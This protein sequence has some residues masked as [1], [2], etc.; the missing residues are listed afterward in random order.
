MHPNTRDEDMQIQ[1]NT[2]HHVQGGEDLTRRVQQI[3]EDS[4]DH[5]AE[6]ITRI[7]AHLSDENGGKHGPNDKRCMLE[8]RMAGLQPIAV[9]HQ[10]E[11]MQLA[12]EGAVEK[13]E[14]ALGHA[15]GRIEDRA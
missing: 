11:S 5:F 2:D 3:I 1:V 14:K 13:L 4:I 12:L 15:L 7:E 6:R 8:A 10:A 9:T